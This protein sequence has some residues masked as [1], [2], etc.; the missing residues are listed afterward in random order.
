[1]V[2]LIGTPLRTMP[3]YA[4][5]DV[6]VD[7]KALVAREPMLIEPAQVLPVGLT[8]VNMSV[9]LRKQF[10]ERGVPGQ[11]PVLGIEGAVTDLDAVQ[12]DTD[13]SQQR[14]LHCCSRIRSDLAQTRGL[15]RLGEV[16]GLAS[17][18]LGQTPDPGLTCRD[19]SNGPPKARGVR[20]AAWL[21][22]ELGLDSAL[23]EDAQQP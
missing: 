20:H 15:D 23:R 1:M 10:Q 11:R 2:E 7:E 5:I 16:Y 19:S 12:G 8:H 13:G 17:G 3:S 14:V 21:L 6:A 9:V 22:F 4:L 18:S